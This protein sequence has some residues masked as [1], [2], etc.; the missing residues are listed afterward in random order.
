MTEV[1]DVVEEK[2][3]IVVNSN[4]LHLNSRM[5]LVAGFARNPK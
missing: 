5:S 1:T 3:F 4:V 2:L